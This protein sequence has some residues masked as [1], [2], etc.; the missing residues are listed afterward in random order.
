MFYSIYKDSTELARMALHDN[1]WIVENAPCDSTSEQVF[2]SS[3]MGMVCQDLR[4]FT[5]LMSSYHTLKSVCVRTCAYVHFA[6]LLLV[7]QQVMTF[8]DRLYQIKSETAI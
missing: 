4:S 2:V 8:T 6:L 7:P 3:V 1:F 5:G